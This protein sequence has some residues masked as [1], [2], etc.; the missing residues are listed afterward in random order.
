MESQPIVL[1]AF[2][3]QDNLGVGYI[4]SILHQ[5]HYLVRILDFRLGPQKI[6]EHLNNLKPA[7]VGFS[8]IFQHF[9]NDFREMIRFLRKNGITCHFSAGGHYP[10]LRYEQLLQLIPEL[11]SVVLFEGEITFL[12]LVQAISNGRD[13]QKLPGLAYRSDGQVHANKLRP[14]EADLDN[15]PPPIRQPLREFIFDKKFATVLAG[16]G[17]IYN[18]S[19]CSI[20]E[21]YSQP[22][23]PVKRVRRPEMVVKE[24]ELLHTQ[25]DCSIFMFQDDDFPI[26]YQKGTWLKDFL[27]EL[28]ESG[29]SEVIMWKI[30]CRPDEIH[31]DSLEQMKARGL[32]LVYLG[33]ESGTDEG[34]QLMNKHITAKTNLNAAQTL[35]DNGIEFDYGYMLFDPDSTFDRVCANLDFLD[36]LVGDGSSP[37]TFCKMLPYAGTKVEKRLIEQG[38]LIGEIGSEDYLFNDPRLDRLYKLMAIAFEKWIGSHAGLLNLARWVRHFLMVFRHYYRSTDEFEHLASKTKQ[39]IR[40]SN[41]AFIRIA[42]EIAEFYRNNGDLKHQTKPAD[43]IDEVQRLHAKYCKELECVVSELEKLDRESIRI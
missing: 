16:R 14:L 35:K 22:P 4:G 19:F 9:I 2:T 8:I 20:R 36:E 37:I 34:L 41:L 13:W 1:I 38:R 33:I 26:A 23:G 11:D 29:L 10:S 17:C 40:E 24:M 28:D 15:F 30:N 6:L 42:R 18:C 7:V 25:K 12:E 32:F 21:F 27:R 43:F 31:I 3:E 5:N 39:T